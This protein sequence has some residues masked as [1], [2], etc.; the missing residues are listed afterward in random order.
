[1]Y[2]LDR[3]LN[4]YSTKGH[5]TRAFMNKWTFNEWQSRAGDE[6]V[7]LYATRFYNILMNLIKLNKY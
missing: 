3:I 7:P 2:A 1:M 4:Y 6:S 5:Y